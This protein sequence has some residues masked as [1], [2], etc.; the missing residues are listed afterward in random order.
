MGSTSSAA[1]RLSQPARSGRPAEHT[2]SRPQRPDT[3]AAFLEGSAFSYTVAVAPPQFPQGD[4]IGVAAISRYN[5]NLYVQ[6][7]WKI[8]RQL[9]LDYGLRYELYS[10]ITERARRTAALAFLTGPSGPEQLYLV[11][12]EPTY[13]W[14]G[15]NWGPRVQLSWQASKDFW[16]RAGGALTTIPPNIWQDNLLT[17]SAPYV[18]YPRITAAPGAPLP[19]GTVITPAGR[20]SFA[21]PPDQPAECSGDLAGL[22]Q[23]VSRN[24][25]AQSGAQAERTEPERGICGHGR[26]R[27]AGSGIPQR[28][29]R[30]DAGICAVHAI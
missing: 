27:S 1:A 21:E 14:R 11:N 30:C 18:D 12:A 17:G 23:F 25:V 15:N 4:Q 29:S 5:L 3:L 22:P 26:H 8:S 9:S 20:G 19:V 6:E 7:T 16:I 24:L 28:F 10:P 2:T 13:R